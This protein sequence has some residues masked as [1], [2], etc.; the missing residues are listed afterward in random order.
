MLVLAA[1]GAIA[2]ALAHKSA[3]PVV[4]GDRSVEGLTDEL[5][6]RL[7][8]QA[9]RIQFVDAAA[10][11]GVDFLHF[12]A[13]RSRVLPEDVSSG[14]AFVDHDNDGDLDIFLVNMEPVDPAKKIAGARRGHGLFRNGGGGRFTEV[15]QA[16]GVNTPVH[17]LGVAAGDADG[18]GFLDLY[19][20]CYGPNQLFRNQGDGTF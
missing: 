3:A 12:G 1:V 11:A 8:P 7:P 18:D 5:A 16:A 2:L 14:C 4:P 6:R 20:T 9:P 13:V 10:E 17:G 19:V 15:S